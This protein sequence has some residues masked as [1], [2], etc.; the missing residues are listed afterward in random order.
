M[1]FFPPP[2]ILKSQ[3]SCV[4][5]RNIASLAKLLRLTST[6]KYYN[7]PRNSAMLSQQFYVPLINFAF[8]RQTFSLSSKTFAF[9]RQ[10]LKYSSRSYRIFPSQIHCEQTQS[11]FVFNVTPAFHFHNEKMYGWIISGFYYQI[12]TN[13]SSSPPPCLFRDSVDCAFSYHYNA[14]ASDSL[15]IHHI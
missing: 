15:I 7:P 4:A 3:N 2:Y 5:S 9:S 10:V 1:N 6:Q 14:V 11:L 8:A 13:S 12:K